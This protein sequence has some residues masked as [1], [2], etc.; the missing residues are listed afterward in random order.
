MS[1][2]VWLLVTFVTIIVGFG[3]IGRK[4]TKKQY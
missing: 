2:M 3:K 1:C 4:K